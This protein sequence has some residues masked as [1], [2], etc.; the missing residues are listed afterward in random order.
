MLE[1]IPSKADNA[2]TIAEVSLIIYP[3][4]GAT[5]NKENLESPTMVETTI[6]LITSLHS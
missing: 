2:E 4:P 6:S 1:I 3:A 5:N